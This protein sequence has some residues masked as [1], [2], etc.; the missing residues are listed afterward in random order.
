MPAKHKQLWFIVFVSALKLF[1][2]YFLQLGNDEVYY[3]TYAR[4][5]QLNYF[6]HPPVVGL[7]LKF[8]SAD[9]L[10]RNEVFLRLGFIIC[11][12]INMW[13]MIKIGE[14]LY[15]KFAGWMA[16][17]LFTASVYA[18]IISGFMIMP[19]SPMLVFWL[20]A[21]YLAVLVAKHKNP[22]PQKLLL[23]G[24]MAGFA[25]LSK[26]SAVMLWVGMV[27]F[28]LLYKRDLL[29][30]VYL[31]L[32]A[33]ITAFVASPIIFWNLS[34]QSGGVDYHA[35]RIT[36]LQELKPLYLIQNL[37]GEIAYTNPINFVLIIAGAFYF[38][39][40]RVLLKASQKLISCFSLPLILFVWF[41]ALFNQTLPHWTGPS[42]T[43]LLF[44]A[45]IFLAEKYK[46]LR[47]PPRLL[48][49][50]NGL[51]VFTVLII[52]IAAYKLPY[53]FNSGNQKNLGAGDLLLDFSGWK[54]FNVDFNKLYRSDTTMG[55]MKPNSFIISDY[56]FPAAHLQ[57]YV[58][59]ANLL[60]FKAVGKLNDIHHYAWL[61][62][63]GVQ[64]QPGD[65]AY[66]IHVSNYYGKPD[67]VLLN[68]F[69]NQ[70]S[71]EEIIQYRNGRPVRKFYITRLKHFKGDLSESGI[72]SSK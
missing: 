52:S 59:D 38:L 50:A 57:W 66:L 11:G 35:N 32:S 9:L 39:R 68:K 45:A 29:R 70:S 8:F 1:L 42:Y 56:W 69:S 71:A 46:N 21:F 26:V 14:A 30:S 63:A 44:L 51:I 5:L 47:K 19:D 41:V 12:A 7:I 67:S 48:Y 27:S 23:F 60:P 58:A 20:S 2:S 62:K 34:N 72:I 22:Q 10:L 15:N 4:H 17:L 31:Y 53:S 33:L 36:N 25:I 49:W 6:D 13:L 54:E 64:L 16:C 43:I 37:L 3:I 24:L 65:D 61:N 18:N 40:R 28:V 55:K